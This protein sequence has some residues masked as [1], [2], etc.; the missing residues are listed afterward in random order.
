VAIVASVAVTTE[1]FMEEL[2]RDCLCGHVRENGLRDGWKEFN[3]AERN[4]G[5]VWGE[6]KQEYHLNMFRVILYEIQVSST[7]QE[8]QMFL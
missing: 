4:Q 3:A 1:T 6:T 8:R 5:T 2:A 7:N